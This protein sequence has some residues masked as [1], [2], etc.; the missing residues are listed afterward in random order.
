MYLIDTM[1]LPEAHDPGWP[2]SRTSFGYGQ[3]SIGARPRLVHNVACAAAHGPRPAGLLALHDPTCRNPAC[4][5]IHHLR[6]G[7]RA[8]N[9]AD[10]VIAGTWAA[11]HL[12]NRARLK[13][14][15]VRRIRER[16]ATG[17]ITM[18]EIADELRIDRDTVSRV[19]RRRTYVN[20]T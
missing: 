12:S 9:E 16:W 10:K 17:M 2:Y 6:W 1:W 20:V 15:Q 18:R 13:P 8:D 4:F 19:V 3:V 14:E 5:W 11:S 7:T